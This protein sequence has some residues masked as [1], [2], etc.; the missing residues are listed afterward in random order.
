M[1][2]DGLVA[3]FPGCVMCLSLLLLKTPCMQ[4]PK[5]YKVTIQLL[6]HHTSNKSKIATFNL[7]THWTQFVNWC[8]GFKK[9]NK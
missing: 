8:C 1:M 4:T 5:A 2:E 7:V 3:H 9:I 6:I